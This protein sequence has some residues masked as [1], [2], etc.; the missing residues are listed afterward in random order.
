MKFN[1]LKRHTQNLKKKLPA[2][3]LTEDLCLETTKNSRINT[4]KYSQ[5]KKLVMEGSR[6]LRKEIQMADKYF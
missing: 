6:V 2:M 1:Q 3:C 4:K 5:I